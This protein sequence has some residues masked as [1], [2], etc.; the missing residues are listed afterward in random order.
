[1]RYDLV[2]V[3]MNE[4][5]GIEKLSKEWDFVECIN[6]FQASFVYS[7]YVINQFVKINE[8]DNL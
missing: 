5:S 1:M 7:C 3:E 4:K 8:K 2:V 6:I